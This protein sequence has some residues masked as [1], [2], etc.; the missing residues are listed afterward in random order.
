MKTLG[1]NELVAPLSFEELVV[2][3]PRVIVYKEGGVWSVSASRVSV[4]VSMCCSWRWKSCDN[5]VQMA[6]N[7]VDHIIKA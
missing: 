7:G 2:S 6:Q 3:H 1:L 4:G 5:A